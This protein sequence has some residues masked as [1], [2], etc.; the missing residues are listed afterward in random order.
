MK[1]YQIVTYDPK[2][3][4]W[5]QKNK[6]SLP[7]NFET[8]KIICEKT[9]KI[10]KQKKLRVLDLMAGIGGFLHYCECLGHSVLGIEI[11]EKVVDRALSYNI[12]VGDSLS[13]TE[14]FIDAISRKNFNLLFFSPPLPSLD[15]RK[16]NK[17]LKR[18]RSTFEKWE[19]NCRKI[20]RTYIQIFSKGQNK[21]AVF[22][23]SSCKIGQYDVPNLLLRFFLDE[24]VNFSKKYKCIHIFRIKNVRISNISKHCE[25]IDILKLQK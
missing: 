11:N 4:K 19:I 25:I 3:F 12:V 15:P 16:D 10:L 17:Y 9:S 14:R 7:I 21:N 6:I 18:F 24:I 23:I 1:T 8:T 2:L 22:V 5:L 13:L 20:I